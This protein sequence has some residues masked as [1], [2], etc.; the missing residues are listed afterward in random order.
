MLHSGSASDRHG[1]NVIFPTECG[2]YCFNT[3]SYP[4]QKF[5]L[6]CSSKA[7]SLCSFVRYFWTSDNPFFWY[8]P[9]K[10]T[11]PRRR[12]IN[13]KFFCT[14]LFNIFF[15]LLKSTLLLHPLCF[16]SIGK[17]SCK[18]HTFLFL[19]SS[20]QTYPSYYESPPHSDS[21]LYS[22]YPFHM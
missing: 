19:Y 18:N 22:L 16:Y 7:L 15:N 20:A 3:I 8:F 10:C 6:P 13:L 21:E 4:W 2:W 12:L 14:V 1:V 9:I 11:H 5:K 17:F